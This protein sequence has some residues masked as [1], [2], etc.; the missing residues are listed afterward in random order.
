MGIPSVNLAP[1]IVATEADWRVNLA[2]LFERGQFIL[3]E[4]LSLF[5]VEFAAAMGAKFAVGVGTGTAA[6]E[7]CLRDAGV[8]GEVLTSAL[9]APFTGVAIATAGC[10]P[11]FADVN[12][13]TLQIDA[14]DAENRVTRRTK[15]IVP[16]HLYGQPCEIDRIAR[17]AT[18]WGIPLV[19]DAAQAHG[20]TYKGQPLGRFSDYICYSFYPTKNLGA[21]GDGGA[22]LTNRASIA[23]RLCSARDGGRRGGQIAYTPGINSRLDDLHCC[24]L[25]AFLTKLAGWN[26]RRAELAALY[27]SALAGCDG[28]QLVR[29]DGGSVHHLYVIR[30]ARRDKL[31]AHLDKASIGS[32][33][34][35]PVPLH[36][37]PAF[38]AAKQRKG[39]LPY[40]ERAAKEI[41]SLPLYPYLAEDAVGQ[42][43]DCVRSFYRR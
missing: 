42:V 20:A 34:H 26:A 21:L 32:G 13:E 40:A 11:K 39:S 4:Q 2:R 17:L 8:T 3:G 37:H 5:E 30:A 36:L 19:Q 22:I 12:P 14:A 10:T 23:R 27:D 16:V 9:T 18:S 7:L 28:V 33:I 6:I 35:Y 25:R 41:V 31:R 24:F 15:A 43:A 1:A 29:R 38:A